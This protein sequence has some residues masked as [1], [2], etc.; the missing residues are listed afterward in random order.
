MNISDGRFELPKQQFGI[1]K[2]HL[3]THYGLKPQELDNLHKIEAFSII[4]AG[5]FAT[6][7][8]KRHQKIME[9]ESDDAGNIR[10]TTIVDRHWDGE[11]AYRGAAKRFSDKAVECLAYNYVFHEADVVLQVRRRTARFMNAIGIEWP[12]YN[13]V[14]LMRFTEH[15]PHEPTPFHAT[16]Q[17]NHLPPAT[18]YD[19]IWLE[20]PAGDTS[21]IDAQKPFDTPHQNKNDEA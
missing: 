18:P 19:I 12:Y 16:R 17:G 9:T 11:A 13:Q 3:F 4:R 5:L 21:Q 15:T 2:K 14:T 10:T 20:D 8:H 7:T 1:F 6:L